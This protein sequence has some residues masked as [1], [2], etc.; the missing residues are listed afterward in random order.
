MSGNLLVRFD[1]GRVGHAHGAA[2]SPT[3]LIYR[4]WQPDHRPRRKAGFSESELVCQAPAV[5]Y[6]QKPATFLNWN[7]TVLPQAAGGTKG[8]PSGIAGVAGAEPGRIFEGTA[9]AAGR[10][11]WRAPRKIS[12]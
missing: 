8:Y 11:A 2:L 12:G 4:S 7:S 3:L 9:P 10:R 1:E 6:F 5:E